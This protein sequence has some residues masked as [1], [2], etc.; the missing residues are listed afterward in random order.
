MMQVLPALLLAGLAGAQHQLPSRDA[1]TY[2]TEKEVALGAELANEFRRNSTPLESSA[3]QQYV[4]RIGRQLSPY[5]PDPPPFTYKFSITI[6]AGDTIHLHEPCAFPGGFIFVPAGLF[7]SAQDEAE[8]AGVLAHAIAH[9]A[10]RHGIRMAGSG[11]IGNHAS[12]PLIFLGGWAGTCTDAEFLLPVEYL[13]FA[14][15]NE[16]HADQLAVKAMARVG[17]DPVALK[18]YIR[19]QQIE[20]E[21]KASTVSPLPPRGDRLKSLDAAIAVLPPGTYSGGPEFGRVRQEVR[22][23]ANSLQPSS[24]RKRPSLQR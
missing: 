18:R 12:I 5:F 1:N 10:A 9:V 6:D 15:A 13:R 8:F 4:E 19:R 23:L 7:S 2:S 3:A 11:L 24:V 22:E 14:R 17:Y 21:G 16:L 20:T